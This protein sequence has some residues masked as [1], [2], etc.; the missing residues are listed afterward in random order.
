VRLLDTDILIDIQR[1]YPPALSW[2]SS[3]AEAPA[4]PGIAV[5]ELLW[6]CRDR[7]ETRRV[8]QLVHSFTIYCPTH[9]DCVRALTIYPRVVLSH[10][11]GI[12]DLLIGECAVGLGAT[13]C[14][15]NVK[16]FQAIPNLTTHQPYR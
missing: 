8:R 13:L 3:L 6:G 9:Q 1:L 2:L 10:R 14:T 7:A 4:V 12:N 16:H 11:V 15:F 5:L